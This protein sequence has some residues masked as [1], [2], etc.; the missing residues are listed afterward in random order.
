LIPSENAAVETSRHL[1]VPL[2]AGACD[3]P[4][5]ASILLNKN[6]TRLNV[7][8]MQNPFCSG[9]S[10]ATYL[11]TEASKVVLVQGGVL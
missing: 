10:S 4:Q 1:F 9:V 3:R 5:I 6:A 2:G 7:Y 8:H 11:V